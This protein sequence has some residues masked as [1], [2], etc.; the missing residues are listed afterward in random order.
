MESLTI[1]PDLHDNSPKSVFSTTQDFYTMLTCI[2][3]GSVHAFGEKQNC[4]T[5][6]YRKPCDAVVSVYFQFK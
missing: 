1:K 2:V 3:H 4:D 6:I 5:C